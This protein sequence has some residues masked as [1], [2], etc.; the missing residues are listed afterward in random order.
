MEK[1]PFILVLFVSVIGL[2]VANPGFRDRT[3]R[4]NCE[5]SSYDYAKLHAAIAHDAEIA[6]LARRELTQ[7]HVSVAQY[8]KVMRKIDSIKLKQS[9]Q[10][11][12]VR[13]A[14]LK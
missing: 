11:A 12:T 4:E 10:V 14:S 1:A 13:Q 8:N 6:A 7:D 2:L 3:E 5:I 9:R